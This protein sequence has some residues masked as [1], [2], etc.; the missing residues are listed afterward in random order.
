MAKGELDMDDF[1]KQM[2]MMRR[3]GSMKSLMGM[4]P[5]VGSALK[6]VDIDEKQFDRTEAMIQ[7]MTPAE[8]KK[9]EIIK[10]TRKRRIAKGSGTS[11]NEVGKLS[12][13]FMMLTKMMKSMG[14]MG[15]GGKMAAAKAMAG[16]IGGMGGMPGMGGMGV[17]GFS[18]KKST[19]S[20]SG[21]AKKRKPKKRK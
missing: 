16:G 12:K 2:K 17:P 14:A 20:K 10:I 9:P 3:M 1:L 19:K 4:L 15:A 8:K 7:S 11:E 6:D 5:G 21:S 18:M 13:Q